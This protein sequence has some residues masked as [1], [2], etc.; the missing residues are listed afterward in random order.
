MLF[1]KDP[2]RISRIMHLLIRRTM[3]LLSAAKTWIQNK[4]KNTPAH[5]CTAQATPPMDPTFSEENGTPGCVQ[6]KVPIKQAD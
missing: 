3:C 6:L 5:L 4:G 2:N 1:D